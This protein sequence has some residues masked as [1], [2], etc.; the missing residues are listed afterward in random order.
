MKITV[1]KA[2]KK[3]G[4]IKILSLQEVAPSAVSVWFNELIKQNLGIVECQPV[5][6][7]KNEFL[8]GQ[9]EMIKQGKL[10]SLVA[11]NSE[12]HI[13]GRGDLKYLERPVNQHIGEISFGVW[14]G[15]PNIGVSLLRQI[16]KIALESKRVSGLIYNIL[17]RNTYFQNI[18]LQAGFQNVG[19][20]PNF[21]RL[22]DH[23]IDDRVI[24][25]KKI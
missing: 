5:D 17:K 11:M 22:A 4:S 3:G 25:Y 1:N 24:F 8:N 6:P 14:K 13:L 19:T 2:I 21:Y 23:S 20:I 18:F 15:Y 16:E 9:L 10:E 7:H 12:G